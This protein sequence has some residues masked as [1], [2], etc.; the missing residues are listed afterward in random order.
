M[1]DALPLGPTILI[2]PRAGASALVYHWREA[3]AYRHLFGFFAWRD[4]QVRYKQTLMGCIWVLLQ[5][6]L[7]MVVLSI[8][9]GDFFATTSDGIPYPLFVFCGLL[10]WTAFSNSVMSATSSVI[11]NTD[12]IKRVYFPRFM[13]P[14]ASSFGKTVDFLIAFIVLMGM[15][16]YYGYPITWDILLI[17]PILFFLFLTSAAVALF[18]SSLNAIYRDTALMLPYFLRIGMLLTPVIYPVRVL[19]QPWQLMVELNPLSGFIEAMRRILL[20]HQPPSYQHLIASCIGAVL[21]FLLG[22]IFFQRMER[23]FLDLI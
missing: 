20:H 19:G 21:L 2:Q 7:E 11:A 6:I 5:P 18:L 13:V 15:M 22:V 17:P 3:W 4:I 9:F 8:V 23:R 1:S 12:I 14:V 16:V 10:P